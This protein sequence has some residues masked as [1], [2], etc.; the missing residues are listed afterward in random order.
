MPYI[1]VKLRHSS[2]GIKEIYCPGRGFERDIPQMQII[3]FTG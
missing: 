2:G 3:S 1:V